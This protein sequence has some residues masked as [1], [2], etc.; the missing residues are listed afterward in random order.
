MFCTGLTVM[1]LVNTR[2]LTG[3]DDPTFGQEQWSELL[4]SGNTDVVFLT[5]QWQRSWWESFGRGQ[6]LLVAAQHRDRTVALAPLF[7]DS[8]MVFFIGSGGSD[9]LDFIGDVS[10]PKVLDEILESARR[11]VRDFLGF[12]FYHLSDNSRTG[13]LLAE[14]GARL[15]LKCFDEGDLPAPR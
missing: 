1:T 12:R 2:T 6:L 14:V 7:A 13:R 4:A 10:E 8:G 3:F 9:Y 15:H 11:Q 5:W